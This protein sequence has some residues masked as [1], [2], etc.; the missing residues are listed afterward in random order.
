[1][2]NRGYFHYKVCINYFSLYIQRHEQVEEGDVPSGPHLALS[3]K[4]KEIFKDAANLIIHHVKRQ[5]GKKISIKKLIS[6]NSVR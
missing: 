1:M 2:N 5:T 4:N 3:Y 6:L